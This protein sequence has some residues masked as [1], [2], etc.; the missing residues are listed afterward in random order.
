MNT[1]TV[2][3]TTKRDLGLAPDYVVP[4]MGE[5]EVPEKLMEG[6]AKNPIIA[7]WARDG[8]IIDGSAKK[9]TKKR[10][11]LEKQAADLGVEFDDETSDDSI[12]DAIK[13]AKADK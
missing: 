6:F 10:T 8:W 13:A 1:V 11:G 3:N 4:S 2:K 12:V 7:G 9:K 5:I